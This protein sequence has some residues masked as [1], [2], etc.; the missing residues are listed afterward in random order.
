MTTI[1]TRAGKGSSLSWN[2]VDTNFTN[3]NKDK[4]EINSPTFTGTVSG[5][6]S[7][8]VGLGNVNNTND[9]NK[10]IS[11]AT[12]TALDLKVSKD[13]DT[14]AATLPVGTTAQRPSNGA[15]KLRY[16]TTLNLYEGFNSTTGSWESVGGGVHPIFRATNTGG[17]TPASTSKVA[18]TTELFDTAS[19]YDTTLSR[20][21]PTV[22]GYYQIHGVLSGASIPAGGYVFPKIYKNG[23]LYETG[24]SAGVQ[25]QITSDFS[26]NV[27]AVVYLNGT[28]DYVELWSTIVSSPSINNSSFS[29]F[30]IRN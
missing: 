4:A 22:A 8:M 12:Q 6:T 2:E 27:S 16:N 29:G 19:C 20:F 25:G 30:L 10:P 14:G 1:T 9:L 7:T 15:G 13:S 23:S 26:T 24:S 11:T 21:T 5:I 18:V 17:A 28:T 3:L